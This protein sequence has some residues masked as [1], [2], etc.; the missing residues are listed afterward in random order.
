MNSYYIMDSY[1][2]MS[3]NSYIV[4]MILHDKEF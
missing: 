2:I 4:L 3:S 1:N